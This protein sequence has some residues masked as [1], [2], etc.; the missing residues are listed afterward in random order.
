LQQRGRENLQ[1]RALHYLNRLAAN[2][3]ALKC[4]AVE[5]MRACGS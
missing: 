1:G 5:V 4:Q 2:R 3:L